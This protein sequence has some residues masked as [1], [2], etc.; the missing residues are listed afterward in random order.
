MYPRG[1]R[2]V[3]EDLDVIVGEVY[4]VLWLFNFS[5]CQQGR[6]AQSKDTGEVGGRS[7]YAR[8]TKVLNGWYSVTYMPA[9]KEKLD[10]NSGS[11][12][13]K[14][15]ASVLS[16]NA[17]RRSSSLSLSGLRYEREFWMRSVVMRTILAAGEGLPLYSGQVFESAVELWLAW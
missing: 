11:H 14:S 3:A 12:T 5:G 7:T 17:P 2:E 13:I 9:R 1:Q 15:V 10:I 4:R 8:D 6:L 16:G